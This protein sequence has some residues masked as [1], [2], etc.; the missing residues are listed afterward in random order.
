MFSPH[1]TR[2]VWA[3]NLRLDSDRGSLC[4]PFQN[5]SG[6]SSPQLP[7][8]EFITPDECYRTASHYLPSIP[9]GKELIIPVNAPPCCF[10]TTDVTACTVFA[11]F[12]AR[13]TARLISSSETFSTEV[14]VKEQPITAR[15]RKKRPSYSPGR[16]ATTSI[17]AS[18][19]PSMNLSN[20]SSNSS[21][22]TATT[23]TTTPIT[24][25]S[26][27]KSGASSTKQRCLSEVS[28]QPTITANPTAL[29]RF[30]F[31]PKPHGFFG[32]LRLFSH[33]NLFPRSHT[34]ELGSSEIE[35]VNV[36][37]WEKKGN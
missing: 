8:D 22:S 29:Q 24:T 32:R 3:P 35:L 17:D 14:E 9:Q 11:E 37:R 34:L 18:E 26:S 16:H 10:R 1:T 4:K 21:S 30:N 5:P 36:S 13:Q 33:C 31:S 28:P 20:S 19:M 15:E 25:S 12:C 23:A 7:P 2:L 27:A 6:L